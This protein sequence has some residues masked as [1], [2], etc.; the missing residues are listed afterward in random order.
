MD[1]YKY[2]YRYRQTHA[3]K[4]ANICIDKKIHAQCTYK[5]MDRYRQNVCFETADVSSSADG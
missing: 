3:L 1:K 4:Q 5:Y 2:L